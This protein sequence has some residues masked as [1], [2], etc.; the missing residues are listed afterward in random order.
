M[1]IVWE[2]VLMITIVYNFVTSCYFLG[3]PGFPTSFWIY[4]EF[5][6]EVAMVVDIL[7]RYCLLKVVIK[8]SLKKNGPWRQ[9][10]MLKNK[11]DEEPL[12]MILTIASS[13][14][15]S[16]ILYS[17]ANVTL[18]SSIWLALI[19]VVK[20]YRLK[21]LNLYFDVRD[22]R[23]KKD[24]FIRTFEASLYIIMVTHFLACLWLF[25]VRVDP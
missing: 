9:I 14:P 8:N 10:N 18:H 3:L 13:V 21:L 20:L 15:T 17:S 2:N 6:T 19:R 24:S 7:I 4:L 25:I 16:I 5:L 23:S 22:I 12:S 1:A 11:Q